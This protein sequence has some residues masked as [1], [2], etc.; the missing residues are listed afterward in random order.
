MLTIL[1][2]IGLLLIIIAV[3]VLES[4][5]FI[6]FK[7]EETNDKVIFSKKDKDIIDLVS[8]L[9]DLRNKLEQ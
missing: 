2:I 7:P 6:R 4:I 5:G 8:Q 1:S 9:A 3:V